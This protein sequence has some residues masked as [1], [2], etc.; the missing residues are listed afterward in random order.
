MTIK[1]TIATKSDKLPD[2]RLHQE[3]VVFEASFLKF[4]MLSFSV[5]HCYFQ[6]AERASMIECPHGADLL[7]LN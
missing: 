3:P 1:I 2:R 7:W 4:K 6:S 5:P